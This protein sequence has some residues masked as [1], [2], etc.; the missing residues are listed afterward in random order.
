VKTDFQVSGKPTYGVEAAIRA[1]LVGFIS[2]ENICR[3]EF[4]S[5]FDPN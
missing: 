3:Y 1:N 2:R 5:A 4:F